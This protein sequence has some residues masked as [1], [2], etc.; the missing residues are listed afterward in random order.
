MVITL[1][2]LH[3]SSYCCVH[4]PLLHVTQSKAVVVSES[5]LVVMTGK[6]KAG[7]RLGNANRK[8]LKEDI[9]VAG[10]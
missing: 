3:L 5:Y 7:Q 9:K 6:K 4:F 2:R 10:L 8:G 1:E